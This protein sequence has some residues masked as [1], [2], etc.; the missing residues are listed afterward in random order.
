M[1]AEVFGGVFLDPEEALDGGF[2]ED[3]ASIVLLKDINFFSICEHHLIPFFGTVH[4]GYIPKGKIVGLSKVVRMI[5]VLSRRLQIQER[6]TNQIADVFVD[7][8][9]PEGVGV[10]MQ[11]EHLCMSLR[12]ET[13]SGSKVVTCITRGVFDSSREIEKRFLAMIQEKP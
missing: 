8:L 13:N 9:Q 11:A 5:N 3:Y 6:L 12:E 2:D 7:K 1:Y 10:F 4:V